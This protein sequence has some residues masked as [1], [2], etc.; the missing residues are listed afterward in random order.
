[1]SAL[2]NAQPFSMSDKSVSVGLNCIDTPNLQISD[3]S[4]VPNR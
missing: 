3:I 2:I 4:E 1:M